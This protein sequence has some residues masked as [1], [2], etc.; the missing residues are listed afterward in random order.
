MRK[1][2]FNDKYELTKAVLSGTKTMTRRAET[3][4]GFLPDAI[5]TGFNRFQI[6]NTGIIRCHNN[7]SNTWIEYKTRYKVGEVVA[8][9]QSYKDAGCGENWTFEGDILDA[10]ADDPEWRL[11]FCRY[12]G[13]V[14]GWNNKMFVRPNLMPHQVKITG[15]KIER[16]QDIN[17]EDCRLEGILKD[18]AY[19]DYNGY[20]DDTLREVYASLINAISGKGTWER[21]PWVVCYSFELIK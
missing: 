2:I 16:L 10:D 18:D 14:A 15:I 4:C 20:Y 19:D 6:L 8:V 1:I 12:Y 9:A 13:E 7:K 3:F 21:N 17:D 11:D 5:N